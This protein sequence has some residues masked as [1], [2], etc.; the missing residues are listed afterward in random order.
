MTDPDKCCYKH[1]PLGDIISARLE[2]IEAID[3]V[4]SDANKIAL[5]LARDEINRRMKE[6]NGLQDK[7]ENQAATF[8]SKEFYESKHESLAKDIKDLLLWKN[9]QAGM[10][11]ASIVI[12]I[13]ALIISTILLI[14]TITNGKL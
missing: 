12:G 8:L 5:D 9:T 1:C 11:S 13:I 7:L 10:H 2:K 14:V 6:S 3:K 4:R